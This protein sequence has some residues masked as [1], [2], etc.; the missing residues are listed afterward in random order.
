MSL[1]HSLCV[2][3][4]LLA[5]STA[6]GPAAAL[7]A[8]AATH[9]ETPPAST[10]DEASRIEQSLQTSPKPAL[11]AAERQLARLPVTDPA[12]SRWLAIGAEAAYALALPAT[13]VKYTKEALD[14]PGLDPEM[15]QR[16]TIALA[17]AEDLS[18]HSN[19]SIKLM[20]TVIGT[21]EQGGFDPQYMVD[22]LSAR[23]AAYY[24]LGNFRAA[25]ADL[26][27]AYPLTPERGPRTI[28]AD[29]AT[30]LGNVYA[31]IEDREHA[32]QFYKEAIDD[33]V[34]NASWVRASIAEYS[35]ATVYRRQGEW[36]RSAEYFE[37]SLR[38]SK[39]SDDTQG[40]AYAQFGL[41]QVAEKLGEFD[42]AERMYLASLP[43][44]AEA[45]DILP[46]ANI[47]RGLASIA[48]QRKQYPLALRQI[49]RSLALAGTI[50]EFDLTYRLFELRAE[51]EYAMGDFKAAY[52]SQKK[53]GEVK[54]KW[55]EAR[56]NESLS[57]MRVRFD[58]ER[59]AQQNALLTKENQLNA[60]KLAEQRQTTRLYVVSVVALLLVLGLLVFL[61]Y[62]SKQVRK[63]LA[64][65]AL[66]DELTGVANRRHV[67][68][69]LSAEVERARRYRTPLTIAM[70]D[71]DHFKQINDRFGHAAGDEV[72]QAF[73]RWLHDSLRKTDCFGRIG[74]E[75]F[76]AVLPHTALEEARTVMERMRYGVLALSYPMLEEQLQPS[77]SI[78][79]AML[80]EDD[81]SVEALVAR[82]D[83]AVYRA[84]E[85]GRNRVES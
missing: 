25:L 40:V 79:L 13:A 24:S 29:I 27:R 39:L 70:F 38:H 43:V 20:M 83:D 48:L 64:A 34:A 81:A 45:G 7:P 6:P 57:E 3:A 23:A 46:Q 78:G 47:A 61:A 72:L 36:A 10:D 12:R 33:S 59:Q 52:L 28:K 62:R 58:T 14:R 26:L 21:L 80:S 35:L 77:V 9:V 65:Q 18:G 54:Q 11:A 50:E 56:N 68:A 15:Q 66:T 84:K 31:A 19:E 69:V 85:A 53:S 8:A 60:S 1:R 63:R 75:E 30:S 44:F 22:A 16:L 73:A 32:E 5:A 49:E 67:M 42:R 76:L 2:A 55:L 4:C 41:A 37:Q 82:A 17:Q 71:L 51:V 74:G